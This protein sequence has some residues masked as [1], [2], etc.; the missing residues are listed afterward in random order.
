VTLRLISHVYFL[1]QKWREIGG[2]APMTRKMKSVII[3]SSKIGQRPKAVSVNRY[4][5]HTE[6]AFYSRKLKEKR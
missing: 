2:G 1:A 5:V 4:V 6:T 3:L